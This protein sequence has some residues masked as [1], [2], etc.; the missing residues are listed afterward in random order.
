MSQ[1]SEP[2]QPGEIEEAISR[3]MEA[4]KKAKEINSKNEAIIDDISAHTPHKLKRKQPH[5]PRT[6]LLK[7]PRPNEPIPYPR[8]EEEIQLGATPPPEIKNTLNPAS[9]ASPG[10]SRS[11][12]R[13]E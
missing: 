9:W 3:A 8:A 6:P 2:P 5:S 12:V 7:Q 13:S 1:A 10:G 4:A 11:K